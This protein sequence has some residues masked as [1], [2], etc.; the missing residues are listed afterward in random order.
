MPFDRRI[1]PC[2]ACDRNRAKEPATLNNLWSR[3]WR[4]GTSPRV[5]RQSTGGLVNARPD[6]GTFR[7][8]ISLSKDM[9]ENTQT[10]TETGKGSPLTVHSFDGAKPDRDD[11]THQSAKTGSLMNIRGRNN[12]ESDAV[13]VTGLEHFGVFSLVTRN[14]Y[15]MTTVAVPLDDKNAAG[16]SVHPRAQGH[17]PSGTAGTQP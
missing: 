10:A 16:S 1:W 17:L 6:L 3:Q 15:S 8:T 14:A 9:T 7:A 2:L 5:G 4:R 12:S 11:L 13:S